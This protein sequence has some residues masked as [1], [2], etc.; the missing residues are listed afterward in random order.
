M[1]SPLT[2]ARQQLEAVKPFITALETASD[3]V[4]LWEKLNQHEHFYHTTLTVQVGETKLE[5]PAYRSQHNSALG[6][7]KGGIRFHP[8]VSADEVQALSMWMTWKCALLGL[9]YGGG[10]GGIAINPRDLSLNEL[11]TLS[12]AYAEWLTKE[13]A[14]GPWIDIP[15][16]DVNTNPKI[17]GWMIDTW[18]K[19]HNTRLSATFTGKPLLLG[20]SLGREEA[21]GRGG[22]LIAQAFARHKKWSAPQ[23]RVSVQGYGN[24]GQFFVS[25]AYELGFP[26]IAVSDSSGTIVNQAG[27]DPKD[28]DDYKKKYRTFAAAAQALDLQIF[29][30]DHILERETDILVPAALEETIHEKNASDIH[31]K[32]I[33]ELANGP[34]TPVAEALLTESGVEILPDILCNAGGVTVSYLEWVQNLH[35]AQ[36]TL[37]QVRAELNTR[38]MMAF[39]NVQAGKTNEL[40][41]R[42]AAY[43]QAVNR[44]AQAEIARAS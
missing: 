43:I 4:A 38:M 19:L 18:Q 23:T 33:L 14:I 31:A 25:T 9:P 2:S 15:A 6:P 39:E 16:P 26:I 35:G 7:Y 41:W 8:Q 21:T 36:W 29:S 44:V 30:S 12:R 11:E 42:Q 28:L 13:N 22:A 32:M 3:P 40:T 27:F 17:M 5:V 1:S 37:E 34:V 20:G 10:K 24:V